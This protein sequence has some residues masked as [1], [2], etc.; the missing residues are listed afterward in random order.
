MEIHPSALLTMAGKSLKTY[1]CAQ[2]FWLDAPARPRQTSECVLKNGCGNGFL[3]SFL[4][5]QSFGISINSGTLHEILTGIVHVVIT[6]NL[7][8]FENVACVYSE[9][10]CVSFT[11]LK[12]S[13]NCTP[14][15]I[16]CYIGVHLKFQLSVESFVPLTLHIQ[17]FFFL[18]QWIP[19]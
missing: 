11:Y 10:L 4:M 19:I 16:S 17:V 18:T 12:N 1:L 7:F 6:Q 5:D 15:Y 3:L 13:D 9:S 8:L 14:S 2:L